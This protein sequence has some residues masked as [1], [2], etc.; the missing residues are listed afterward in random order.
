MIPADAVNL[1]L[2][3]IAEAQAAGQRF[4]ISDKERRLTR[5]PD[6]AVE[7]A[8]YFHIGPLAGGAL[9]S[10]PGLEPDREILQPQSA[11]QS[12]SRR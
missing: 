5:N 4:R 1:G 3:E 10:L 9:S 7:R 8:G 11:R 2:P 6:V 12:S